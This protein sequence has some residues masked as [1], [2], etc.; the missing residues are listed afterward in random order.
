MTVNKIAALLG[1]LLVVAVVVVG[2]YIA[3]SPGEQRLLRFDER[4]IR[5]LQMISRSIQTHADKTD[6]L[7]G[8]LSEL[9]GGQLLRKLPLD[10]VS[11]EAYVFEPVGEH[12]YRLCA[13]FSRPSRN[14]P[15]PDAWSHD[16]GY[17]CFDFKLL[18]EGG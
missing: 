16:A 17:Q 12:G 2:L 18:H 7:P 4:R 9:V 1:S 5:D 11:E 15:Q 10:P 14:L 3:G 13:E 6:R 8:E